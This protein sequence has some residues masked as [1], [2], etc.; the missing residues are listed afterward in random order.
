VTGFGWYL[1]TGGLSEGPAALE[2]AVTIFLLPGM[3]VSLIT[4][5]NVHAFSESVAIIANALIYALPAYAI[6]IRLRSK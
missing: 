5:G 2:A 1:L 4:S 6:W 3:I